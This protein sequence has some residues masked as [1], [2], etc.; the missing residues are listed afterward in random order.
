MRC[1]P[2]AIGLV[3]VACATGS[4]SD[5]LTPSDGPITREEIVASSAE[6]AFELIRQHR[7]QWLRSVNDGQQLGVTR[8]AGAPAPAVDRR[9]GW[10]VYVGESGTSADELRRIAAS[11]V[12]EVR[13]ISPR[14]ARPDGSRCD[15]RYA[16]IHVILMNP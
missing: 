3:V 4:P 15:H 2:S 9:C 5:E 6:N 13:L 11:N 10:T 12:A 7:R 8:R 1:F 14:Q 16:A